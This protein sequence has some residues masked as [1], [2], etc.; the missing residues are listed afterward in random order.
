MKRKAVWLAVATLAGVVIV[1][2]QTSPQPSESSPNASSAGFG[3]HRFSGCQSVP[4]EIYAPEPKVRPEALKGL[5]NPVVRVRLV[6]GEDGR[7]RG[8]EVLK[9][10]SPELDQAALDGV[11]R[12]RFTPARK[13]G[14]PVAVKLNIELNLALSQAPHLP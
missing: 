11:K 5:K 12:W 6:V 13:E 4:C 1:Q 3:V 7:P 8:I 2:G 14:K 10:V 9:G